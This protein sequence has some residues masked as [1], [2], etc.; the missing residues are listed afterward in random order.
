MRIEAAD[1]LWKITADAGLV[2]P[3]LVKEVTTEDRQVRIRALRL[4]TSMGRAARPALGRLRALL[5]DERPWVRQAAEMAIERI[6]A[7]VPHEN[8]R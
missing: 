6:D 5:N 3:A 1:A 7:S 4:L 2:L 8:D